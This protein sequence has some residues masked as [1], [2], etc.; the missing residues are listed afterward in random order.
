MGIRSARER[1]IL[2]RAELRQYVQTLRSLGDKPAAIAD[3]CGISKGVVGRLLRQSAALGGIVSQ[4]RRERLSAFEKPTRE[5]ER[6]LA[7][8]ELRIQGF[9]VR[10]IAKHLD[11][12]VAVVQTYVF[13]E[14]QLRI[15]QEAKQTETSRWLQLARLD[16]LVSALFPAALGGNLGAVDRIAKLEEMRSKLLG[17][18]T[19]I[20]IDMEQD[21]REMAKRMGL[22]PEAA[23][24][25]ATSILKEARQLG[26]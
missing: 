11:L 23:V 12:P 20:R 2:R 24:E 13:E 18:N 9:D 4:Q 25:T 10:E 22:D 6:R 17:T 8:Y 15:E 26:Q 19:P 1:N 14:L 3:A 16:E 5:D 7:V 21:I